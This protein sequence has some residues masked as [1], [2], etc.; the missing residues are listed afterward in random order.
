MIGLIEKF[1]VPVPCSLH[2]SPHS[3]I[4]AGVAGV[5]GTRLEQS[6]GETGQGDTEGGRWAAGAGLA[7]PGGRNEASGG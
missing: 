7:S 6:P 3:I 5:G 2:G 1:R 4:S